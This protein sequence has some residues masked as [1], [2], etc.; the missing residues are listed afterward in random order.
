MNETDR[1]WYRYRTEVSAAD[2]LDAGA[3]LFGVLSAAVRHGLARPTPD[4]LRIAG[5][6]RDFVLAAS[7]AGGHGY[8]SGCGYSDE[9]GDGY[10]SGTGLG[11][12]LKGGVCHGCGDGYF[13]GDGA[14]S[15]GGYG[16]GVG[17]GDWDGLGVGVGY[18]YGDGYGGGYGHGYGHASSCMIDLTERNACD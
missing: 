15:G 17:Y 18:G 13:D 2:L 14:G 12:M 3:C 10:S 5:D 4:A 1:E 8:G 11:R 16:D 9:S 6:H 7:R